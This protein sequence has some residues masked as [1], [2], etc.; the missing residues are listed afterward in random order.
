VNR[1]SRELAVAQLERHAACFGV[2]GMHI[3]G[4]QSAICW[5]SSPTNIP[6][7]PGLV[8]VTLQNVQHCRGPDVCIK[9]AGAPGVTSQIDDRLY[10]WEAMSLLLACDDIPEDTQAHVIR[11]LLQQ[12]CLQ[13]TTNLEGDMSSYEV[14]A[15]SPP[16]PT[17]VPVGRLP[18]TL[19]QVPTPTMLLNHAL[20]AVARLSKG[21]SHDR[22]TARRP[23][24]GV[25][26]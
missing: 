25:L 3:S 14:M 12:L 9:C 22:M 11:R 5:H 21:F 7:N 10:A 15:S 26:L 6:K 8:R 20:E 1:C 23:Q 24:V 18:S 2:Q 16:P 13:V 19:E 4:Y 17:R